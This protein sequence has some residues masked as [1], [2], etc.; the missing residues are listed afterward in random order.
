[1]VV[2]A[3]DVG[4][5]PKL[6]ASLLAFLHPTNQRPILGAIGGE[7]NNFLVHMINIW[8]LICIISIYSLREAQK[9]VFLGILP[10][11]V[12]PPSLGTF[13]N[14]NVNFGQI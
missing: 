4:T 1:M 11:P 13:R 10:K 7:I 5:A 6:F 9:N 3:A 2:A 12:D 8:D 14:K